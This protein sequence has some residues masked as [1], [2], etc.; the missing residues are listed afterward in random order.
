[1]PRGTTRPSPAERG[2]STCGAASSRDTRVVTSSGRGA[3][4]DS[5]MPGLPVASELQGDVM[6]LFARHGIAVA[7]VGGGHESGMLMAEAAGCYVHGLFAAALICAHASCE[8][9]LAGHLAATEVVPAG[10][11]RWGLGRLLQYAKEHDWY[12]AQ[13]LEGLARLNARRRDLYHLR[14]GPGMGELFRRTYDQ[15]PWR[16]KEHIAEDIE[17]VLRAESFEGLDVALAVRS[18]LLTDG[19]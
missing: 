13:T 2:P 17:R 7:L 18:E 1:M 3:G 4:D 5:D 10:A 14:S 8:R 19:H 6:T 11:E 15:L 9:E 16:G 12:S